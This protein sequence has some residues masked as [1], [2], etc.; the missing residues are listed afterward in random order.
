M[1]FIKEL[2][3]ITNEKYK[4]EYI[5]HMPLDKKYGLGKTKEELQEEGIL[6]ENFPEP[7]YIEG[8]YTIMYWNPIEKKIFYEYEDIPNVI[9]PTKEETLQNRVEALEKSNAEMMNLISTMATP[10][11]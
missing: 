7:I 6:I 9:E 4:I 3:K 2:K 1:Q 10:T 5:H 11:E 8:K